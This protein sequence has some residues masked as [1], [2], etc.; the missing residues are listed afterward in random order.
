[1]P[2]CDPN[3]FRLGHGNRQQAITG[4]SIVSAMY[5]AADSSL[6]PPGS[7]T[8]TIAC[9]VSS[10]SKICSQ[11]RGA[12]NHITANDTIDCPKPASVNSKAIS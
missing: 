12:S 6:F 4:L 10:S 1:M 7:P 9:V 2:W 5:W 11:K 3:V 8:K